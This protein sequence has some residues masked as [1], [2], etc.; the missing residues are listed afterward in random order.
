MGAI[1][2]SAACA[3]LEDTENGARLYELLRAKPVRWVMWA[4]G[5]PLGPTAHFL[6][7][8]AR[9]MGNL[10]AAAAHFEDALA[11]SARMGA[12]PFVARTQV[13]YAV[14]LQR[15]SG[16][17]DAAQ[18]AALAAEAAATAERLGMVGLRARAAALAETVGA[19][20]AAPPLASPAGMRA[21]LP[22]PGGVNV[23]RREGEYWTVVYAGAAI[24][25]RDTKGLHYVAH[26]LAHPTREIH[27]AD[28]ATLGVE[29]G[30]GAR[31]RGDMA[32][33][34][35]LGAVLDPRATAE[36]RRR[37]ADLRDEL[38]E[39][40]TSADAGGAAC[41]RHE[42]ELITHEL[43]AAYGLGGR[44]RR[45]GDPGERLRK[46]VTNQIR[47]ALE[48]IR[49]DHPALGRHLAN[50]IR[51]GFL[52]AYVPEQRIEWLL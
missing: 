23:F 34:S 30:E 17:G 15:R 2:L 6:G 28:L 45:A 21:S 24:H 41:A 47:R 27:V 29:P 37:L 36:Y 13:E 11:M 35:D 19:P 7:L 44:A 42:I 18:A 14:L 39:A 38:A 5:A 52:C 12:R 50:S 25:L 48:R 31:G 43:S 33:E 4:E 22:E 3:A 46:A 32:V 8:L 40:T 1:F 16:P 26:L 49:A 9:T 51:T 10:D 20:A